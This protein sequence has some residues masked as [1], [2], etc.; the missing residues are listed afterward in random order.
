MLGAALVHASVS[1]G[2]TAPEFK[3]K[4]TSG[5]EQ[6]LS[7]YKGKFVVL[8]WVNPGCPFVQ[9]HYDTS[10]MQSTQKAA[11]AK[12]VV[13]LTVSSTRSRRR[14]TTGSP[15]ELAAWVKEKGAK[16]QRRR[17]WTTTAKLGQA[18][19]AR[20]TPHMY[21][22][23]P[24]GTLVYAGAID[25]KATARKEDV[26]GATNYVTAALE[27]GHGRQAGDQGHVRAV[28]LLDQV[29]TGNGG[30]PHFLAKG[31]SPLPARRF[32]SLILSTWQTRGPPGHSL[33]HDALKSITFRPLQ[34]LAGTASAPRRDRR[35]IVGLVEAEGHL[36]KR[37][38]LFQAVRRLHPPRPH[39]VPPTHS[40]DKPDSNA[41]KWGVS[42]FSWNVGRSPSSIETAASRNQSQRVRR[43]LFEP[44]ARRTQPERVTPRVHVREH[45]LAPEHPDSSSA[46][47]ICR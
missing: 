16:R 46:S 44:G 22:I 7:A 15:D 17:S 43:V 37:L 41:R 36:P 29:L 45:P 13:W 3:V 47:R 39:S 2:Q 31:G 38:L 23:D 26:K 32:F 35:S 30:I 28:R 19:G 18:Y 14:A 40:V 4:D 33:V 10:N 5:K 27:R 11:E 1:V 8:E 21:V 20:T 42:P 12:G 25:S 34:P 6:S 24:E 9:K